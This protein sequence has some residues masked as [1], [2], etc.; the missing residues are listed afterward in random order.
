MF[1]F[2][3]VP[4]ARLLFRDVS[5]PIF[6]SLPP[7]PRVPPP[8]CASTN[9][10]ALRSASAPLRSASTASRS[11]RLAA[12]SARDVASAEFNGSTPSVHLVGFMGS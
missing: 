7:T 3:G 6:P 12:R 1:V 8:K 10:T 11:R 4:P 5:K 2:V 9:A